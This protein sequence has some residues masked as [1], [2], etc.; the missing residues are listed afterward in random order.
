[1]AHNR[2]IIIQ[3]LE[4]EGQDSI[5]EKECIDGCIY[6]ASGVRFVIRMTIEGDT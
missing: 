6:L 1:M 3:E 2:L 4:G 5:G